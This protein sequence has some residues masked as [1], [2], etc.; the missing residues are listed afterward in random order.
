MCIQIRKRYENPDEENIFEE[1]FIDESCENIKIKKEKDL[2][3]IVNEDEDINEYKELAYYAASDS[4]S[5]YEPSVDFN[6]TENN[7]EESNMEIPNKGRFSCT[8]PHCIASFNRIHHFT[9]HLKNVHKASVKEVASARDAYKNGGDPKALGH[10]FCFECQKNFNTRA[11]LL[12]HYKMV[13][14]TGSNEETFMCDVCA[15]GD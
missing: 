10:N 5:E 8:R 7:E 3:R 9:R 15:K 1:V 11:E 14:V 13:H 6:N 2:Q 12:T 4:D